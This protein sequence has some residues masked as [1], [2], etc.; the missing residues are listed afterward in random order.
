MRTEIIQAF[1]GAARDVLAQEIG[2]PVEPQKVK[3]QGGPYKTT[4]VT[5]LIGLAQGIEG[6]VILGLTTETACHYIGH[7]MGEPVE[8]LDELAQS[9]IGELANVIAGRAGALLGERG[10]P[11]VIAPPTII[12]GQ[13]TTLS[14]MSVPRLVVP[15][16]TSV[17]VIELQLAAK[18]RG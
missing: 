6:A 9:G 14:M 11:T 7:I 2:E 5:V 16:Y 3:L 8:E 13:D 4:D 10:Y 1:V 12:L 15:M 17:G 18:E